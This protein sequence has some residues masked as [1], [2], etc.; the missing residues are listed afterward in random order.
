LI[1]TSANVDRFTKFFHY[2]IPEEILYKYIIK[3]LHL[4]LTMILHYLVKLYNYNEADFNGT[5]QLACETFAEFILEDM[6][7][8][9]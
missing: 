9:G 8:P 2:E 6:R 5:L 4:T 1:I 3:I 7:L